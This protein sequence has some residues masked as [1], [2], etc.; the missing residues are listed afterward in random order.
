MTPQG[1]GKTPQQ[2]SYDVIMVGGAIMGASTRNLSTA[3]R[4]WR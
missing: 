2:S 4:H 3:L 1:F